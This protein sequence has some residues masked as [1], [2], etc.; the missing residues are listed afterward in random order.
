LANVDLQG[1]GDLMSLHAGTAP[2]H[3]EKWL[4]S[5]WIRDQPYKFD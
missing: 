1:Q 2:T 5:Q 4:L 3:G